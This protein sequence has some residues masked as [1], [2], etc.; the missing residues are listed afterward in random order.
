MTAPELDETG[1]KNID[2]TSARRTGILHL[3]LAV[4]G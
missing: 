4:T 3:N 1:P 2:L